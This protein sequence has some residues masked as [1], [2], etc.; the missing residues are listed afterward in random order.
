MANIDKLLSN[1]LVPIYTPTSNVGAYL[2]C[3]IFTNPHYT[4]G[5][6]NFKIVIVVPGLEQVQTMPSE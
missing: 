4:L 5:K 3:C 1:K 6:N 2:F